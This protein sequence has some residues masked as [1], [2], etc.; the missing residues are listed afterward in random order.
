MFLG[1]KTRLIFTLIITISIFVGVLTPLD[2]SS[3]PVYTKGSF[4]SNV[5]QPDL[6]IPIITTDKKNVSTDAAMLSFVP[7]KSGNP[8]NLSVG[9]SET[10]GFQIYFNNGGDLPISNPSIKAELIKE[11]D[12]NY[13]I[14]SSLFSSTDQS[15]VT[16][17]P[18]GGDLTFS[19]P[20]DSQVIVAPSST[21]L[22]KNVLTQYPSYPNEINNDTSNLIA[23][24]K[25]ENELTNPLFSNSGYKIGDSLEIGA[26]NYGFATAKLLIQPK[27]STANLPPVLYNQHLSIERGSKS[28]FRP[29]NCIDR[30]ANLPCT[31]SF[32]SFP[33][34]CNYNQQARIISCSTDS[35]TAKV[36]KFSI[37]PTG[38]QGLA[39]TPAEYIIDVVEP[40]AG[41]LII[42][43]KCYKKDTTSDCGSINLTQGD[44]V[45]MTLTIKAIGNFPVENVKIL[46]SF[47]KNELFEI[48]NLDPAG[49]VDL[50]NGK[51]NTNIGTLNSGE[52]KK[53]SYTAKIKEGLK[54]GH[55]ITTKTEVKSDN[56]PV[57]LD[58]NVLTTNIPGQ[59]NLSTSYITCSK[60]DTDISCNQKDLN[61]NDT[62]TYNVILKNSGTGAAY[63]VKI[64]SSYNKNDLGLVSNINNKGFFDAGAGAVSWFAG[65]VNGGETK[66]FSFDAKIS[67]DAKSGDSIVNSVLITSDGYPNQDISTNFVLLRPSDG[68]KNNLNWWQNVSLVFFA[69]IIAL[70][71]IYRRTSGF[72][73]F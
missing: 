20:A 34:F 9:A 35:Q 59:L 68:N 42:E 10:F 14:K 15:S 22:Y 71:L 41:R 50:E 46:E 63:N 2:P 32:D 13:R 11:S 54:N 44:I 57:E 8:R 51:I 21:R 25:T 33:D 53:I 56:A 28:S 37:L 67:E 64:V 62:V 23:D 58:Q 16:S 3:L 18:N 36:T 7:F 48:S 39:G 47:D 60:K 17:E 24:S 26:A 19:V 55:K 6:Q 40:D 61:K 5:L 12:T 31:Y 43:K 72:K 52:T 27:G 49:E 45:N 29:Y 30:D 70:S 65:S 4:N 69:I 66:E 38:S 73:L 1:P